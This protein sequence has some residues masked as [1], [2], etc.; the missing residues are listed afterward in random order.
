MALVPV[1]ENG[2]TIDAEH[3]GTTGTHRDESDTPWLDG[4]A[5]GPA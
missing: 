1:L 3:V 5:T 2:A 4:T